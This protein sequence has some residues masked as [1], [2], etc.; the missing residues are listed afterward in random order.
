MSKIV[1]WIKSNWLLSL[2]ILVVGYFVAR[3]YFGV[4]LYRDSASLDMGYGVGGGGV[5]AKTMIAPDRF[6]PESAPVAQTERLVVQDTDLSLLVKDV[7]GSIEII[8]NAAVS[9]GG[10]MVN[11][12]MNQPEGAATGYITIRVPIEKREMALGEIRKAGVK[13]VSENVYGYDVTDQYVDMEERINQLEKTKAKIEAIMDQATRV[14]DLIEIQ[15]QLNY[16]QQQIDS[17]KGQQKYLEQTAKLT[18]I[19]VNLSTDELAL[20]YTPDEAWRPEAVFKNAVRMMIQ[21]L[22]FFANAV[23]WAVVFIPI[24]ALVGVIYWLLNFLRQRYMK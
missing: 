13:V 11:K 5:I 24:L 6:V 21:V 10:Y 2:L 17:Y 19:T 9:L 8:E 12:N 7:S 15:N 22:R 23:I 16:I 20:P 3:D 1:D 4:S 14:A 18:R